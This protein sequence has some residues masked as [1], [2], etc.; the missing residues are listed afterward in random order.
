M[1]NQGR[2]H[3]EYI[4]LRL[5]ISTDS[6]VLEQMSEYDRKLHNKINMI[7]FAERE[8]LSGDYNTINYLEDNQI[9]CKVMFIKNLHTPT[10]FINKRLD[11]VMS[12]K[13]FREVQFIFITYSLTKVISLPNKLI[14]FLYEEYPSFNMFKYIY[15][16]D[17][18][19]NNLP[20]KTYSIEE[21][22]R[23]LEG[24]WLQ[25]VLEQL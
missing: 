15:V 22:F 3:I 7:S 4:K 2:K 9:F 8:S 13:L 14:L 20:V 24:L 11:C 10:V 23:Y 25:L 21:T 1:L 18:D 16:F 19:N 5:E 17:L 12:E 6:K